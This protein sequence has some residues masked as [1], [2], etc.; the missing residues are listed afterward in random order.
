MPNVV[1]EAMACSLPVIASNVPGNNELVVHGET[2]LLF[3]LDEPSSFVRA[4]TQLRDN[5]LRLRMGERGR[6]RALAAFSW[7]SVA[8]RYVHLFN[9]D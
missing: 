6:T 7:A 3:D 9:A 1:L 5:D 8:E 2:G 4:L